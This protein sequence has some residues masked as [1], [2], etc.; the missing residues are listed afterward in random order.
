ML[1]SYAWVTVQQIRRSHRFQYKLHDHTW[2]TC[3]VAIKWHNFNSQRFCNEAASWRETTASWRS[4]R[5]G[6]TEMQPATFL[7]WNGKQWKTKIQTTQHNAQIIITWRFVQC[8][9]FKLWNSVRTCSVLGRTMPVWQSD[10]AM[11]NIGDL[12][13]R[14]AANHWPESVRTSLGS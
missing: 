4:G 1:S 14:T 2:S 8:T 5:Y 3:I 9:S 11:P 13:L 10:V 12:E 7:S 6:D